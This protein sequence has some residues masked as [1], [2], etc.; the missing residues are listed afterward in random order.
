MEKDLPVAV[1]DIENET[2]RNHVV[3]S[4]YVLFCSSV[5]RAS[6]CACCRPSYAVTYHACLGN[7]CYIRSSSLRAAGQKLAPGIPCET[8]AHTYPV[9]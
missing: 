7:G 8:F 3:K 2:Y 6:L 4:G 1:E 9:A 5:L